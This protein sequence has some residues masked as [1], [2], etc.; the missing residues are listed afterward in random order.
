M[1]PP[2][3]NNA[4]K[5]SRPIRDRTFQAN[6]QKEVSDYLTEQRFPQAITPKLLTSPTQKDFQVI[7]RFLVTELIDPGMVWGKKFD[8]DCI[9]VVRDLRYPAYETVGKTALVA[10]GTPFNWPPLLAM[11]AWLVE[12]CRVSRIYL[13][14]FIL[15]KPFHL[16]SF[17]RVVPKSHSDQVGT[18]QLVQPGRS[19]RSSSRS[20]HGPPAGSPPTRGAAALGLLPQDVLTVV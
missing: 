10:P 6:C 2:P 17:W 19:Q 20:G 1:A 8:D 14:F 4:Q 18:R 15:P 9:Q 12:L 16:R 3:A 5:E 11:L 7:F 13:G